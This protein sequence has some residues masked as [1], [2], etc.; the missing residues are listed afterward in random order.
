MKLGEVKLPTIQKTAV[1]REARGSEDNFER[2]SHGRGVEVIH[3]HQV[4]LTLVTTS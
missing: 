1:S 2:V 4:L 3:N